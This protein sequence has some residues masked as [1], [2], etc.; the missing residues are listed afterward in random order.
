MYISY[1]IYRFPQNKGPHGEA[2]T[3]PQC[4]KTYRENFFVINK[5]AHIMNI[6]LV[7]VG[8]EIYHV[9]PVCNAGYAVEKQDKKAVSAMLK[10]AASSDQQMKYRAT[11]HAESKTYDLYL[12]DLNSK[13][14]FTLGT[15]LT[16]GE[17]K[18]E[19]KGRLMKKKDVEMEE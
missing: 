3:C 8:K 1:G 13:E 5:W 14:T 4:G 9:C 19:L 17:Y 16:R 6:P 2:K 11:Y 12:D 10:E 7:P 15:G 18:Q